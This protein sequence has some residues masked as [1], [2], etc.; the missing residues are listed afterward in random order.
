MK[1]KCFHPAL[2]A[3]IC[4]MLIISVFGGC[5][6][7]GS[8][9]VPDDTEKASAEPMPADTAAPTEAVVFDGNTIVMTSKHI[10]ITLF[11]FGQ[12]YYNG[13]YLQY[14]MYGLMSADQYCDSVIEEVSSFMRAVNA[15]IDAGTELNAEEEAELEEE[16]NAQLDSLI[17]RY[18]EGLGDEV[19]NKTEEA[20][21]LLSKDLEADGLDYESFTR[22]AKGNMRYYRIIG[23]YFDELENGITVSDED[24]NKYIEDEA[25]A[26]SAMTMSDFNQI[27]M[28]YCS[29]QGPSPVC[30]I[31]DCFSVNHIYLAYTVD[32]DDD[33]SETY[34]KESCAEDEAKIEA[35]LP[36]T[37]DFAAFMELVSEYGDDPGMEEGAFAKNGYLIHA[38]LL[39]DYY[40]GFVYAAMN[41]H[42][43]EWTIDVDPDSSAQP[44]IPEL[45]Y[46]TLL[47]GTKVV[48]FSSEF[49]VHYLIVNKEYKTGNVDY[50]VGDEVWKSWV[51]AVKTNRLKDLSAEL[52]EQWKTEYAVETDTATIKAKFVPS[53]K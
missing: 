15:A 11:D 20:I 27:Y 12:S 10:D 21:K 53:E 47:D 41:L 42:E 6:L 37:A 40:D 48:K 1:I 30:F 46:F 3:V 43:G 45:T 51:S 8:V 23:K 17:A 26:E 9:N 49:G 35:A 50:T 33:G 24:V 32:T 38:D 5:R 2:A 28:G 36:N 29:G 19:E 7:N 39:D 34:D 14:Y 22:L 4:I 25:E 18:S 44:Y 16:Y 52:E 13:K 31:K